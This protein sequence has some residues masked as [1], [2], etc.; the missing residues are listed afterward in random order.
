M[1]EQDLKKLD[2]IVENLESDQVDLE[3]NI[4]HFQQG[5]DLVKKCREELK[6]AELKIKE[7]VQQ[8]DGQFEEKDFEL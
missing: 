2:K 1:L 6:K 4:E 5:M 7:I 8:A 3:K